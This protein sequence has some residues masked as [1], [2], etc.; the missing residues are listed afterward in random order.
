HHN[1][2]RRAARREG[3]RHGSQ[4]RRPLR[5]RALLIEGLALGTVYEA[6]EHD[7]T[8]ANA[9]QSA[10]RDGEVVAH[11]VEL[12]DLRLASEK[13][14]A[15]MPHPPPAPIDRKH[16][17]GFF[18]PQT[19]L[20]QVRDTAGH[21]AALTGRGG[22]MVRTLITRR[23]FVA[24]TAAGFPALTHAA[25]QDNWRQCIKCNMMFFAGY[26]KSI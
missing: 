23:A 8:V 18:P 26:R 16:L 22:H 17:G 10:R 11:E 24:C 2:L 1:L 14:L 13:Q 4:P 25:T 9:C 12:G 21:P 6:L 15:R 19:R 3:E 7:R 20:T 5:G